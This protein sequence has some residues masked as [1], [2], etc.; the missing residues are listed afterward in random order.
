M[1]IAFLIFFVIIIS[2]TRLFSQE[3]TSDKNESAPDKFVGTYSLKSDSLRKYSVKKENNHLLL[4]FPG[5]GKTDL[6]LIAGKTFRAKQVQPAANIEFIE[7]S[8]GVV[9]KF[10]WLQELNMQW[11]KI[12]ESFADTL[13]SSKVK[14]LTEYTGKYRLNTYKIAVLKIEDDNLTI[15]IPGEAKIALSVL[16]KDKFTIN[17]HGYDQVFEFMRDRKGSIQKMKVTRKGAVDFIKVSSVV[18]DSSFTTDFTNRKNGFTRADTLRGMLTPLR[19][20]YDVTFYALDVTVEPETKSVHGTTVIRFR[21]AEPFNTMQVDLYANMKIE[22]IL[23]HNQELVYTREYNAVFILFPTT[24]VK[25]SEDEI[26]FFYS[27]SPQSPDMSKLAGGFLWGQ[28][29]NG[30]PWIESVCQGSGASLWWPCKDHLSDK[31][32]SMKISIT[33]PVGLTDISNGRLQRK[34]DLPDNLTRFDWY[35]SYPINTYNVAI[36]IGDYTHFSDVYIGHADSLTLDYYCM[37]YNR[38][39]AKQIFSHIKPMLTLYEKSFGQYPFKRDGFTLL[40]SLYPM[41]HQ[42]AVSMGPM[43]NPVNSNKFDS[44]DLI[45]TAW[46]ESAHEWWGNNITCKDMADLWIH[47]AFATY[48]EV[49]NYETF[50]G[51]ATALKYLKSEPPK[52]TTAIIGTYNVN[53]FHLGDMYS[54]G[55]LMLH[56]LRNIIDNDSLWFGILKG[57]QRDLKFQSII[58]DD[59][60]GYFNKSTGKNLTPFFNQYLRYAAIPQLSLVFKKEGSSLQVQYK[61]DA[62]E[63]AFEMPVKVTTAKDSYGFI[64]PGTTWQTLN[65]PEMKYKDFKVDTV[66]FYI[67][68]KIEND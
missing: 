27:G 2:V 60:I 16:A 51:K 23:H 21:T 12:Y 65:I 62:D 58:T 33:V 49:L 42:S 1:K 5:Q 64:F 4:A 15:D 3:N 67:K 9:T 68:L 55:A 19:T 13:L 46:H 61:W 32:D 54:K 39:K 22:K 44:L 20:C 28:D 14:Y 29:H 56:T 11:T 31:P 50:Y 41:E 25:G 35:V 59:V 24:L 47:E 30:K 45:R 40:E 38:D 7:D 37:P 6:Q 34:I 43:N 8:L 17:G 36:N 63:N 52:N 18:S 48:S 57:I 66:G 53:D 10:L 26:T